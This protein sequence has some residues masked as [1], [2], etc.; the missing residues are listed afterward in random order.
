MVVA[1]GSTSGARALDTASY[2]LTVSRDPRFLPTVSDLTAKTAEALNCDPAD[3]TRLT[4]AV[5]L[6]VEAI[7]ALDGTR[8]ERDLV[9]VRFDADPDTLHVEVA[10]EPPPARRAA[11]TLERALADSGQLEAVRALMPDAEFLAIGGQHV[12]RLICALS[13][14]S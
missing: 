6:I 2:T 3:A 1:M 5:Q 11:W 14:R 13:P 10:T 9:D 7:F 4:G 8:P 12:C